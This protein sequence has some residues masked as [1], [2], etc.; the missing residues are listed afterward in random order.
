MEY[1]SYYVPNTDYWDSYDYDIHTPNKEGVTNYII[2]KISE[3]T[4]I[5][6]KQILKT[7]V[8]KVEGYRGIQLSLNVCHNVELPKSLEITER[9]ANTLQF[10]DV[11][12][13]SPELDFDAVDIYDGVRY[14]Q[15]KSLARDLEHS[16]RTHIVNS[17]NMPEV[18][19]R[20][21]DQIIL[22]LREN[23]TKSINRYEKLLTRYVELCRTRDTKREKLDQIKERLEER[24]NDVIDYKDLLVDR[25]SY[26]T[27]S[28]LIGFIKQRL[29]H[30]DKLNKLRLRLELMHELL[31]ERDL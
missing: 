4:N 21:Y 5:H 10:A 28:E 26:K 31:V 18:D 6:P 19:D 22:R 1:S 24:Y 20:T 12:E 30:F 23:I 14:E 27:V 13:P 2:N 15:P 16:I 25:M 8:V 9:Q 7:P 11:F 17:T 29:E 3:L